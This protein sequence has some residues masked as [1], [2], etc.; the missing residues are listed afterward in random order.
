MTSVTN[1]HKLGD[2]AEISSFSHL[3]ARV[4][5]QE[6][7]RAVLPPEALQNAFLVSSSCWWRPAFLVLW[8]Q[9]SNR[10][11]R[12]PT[13]SWCPHII[14]L[15]SCKD[16][17]GGIS[18]PPGEPRVGARCRPRC[19]KHFA[20]HVVTAQPRAARRLLRERAQSWSTEWFPCSVD[21]RT[22]LGRGCI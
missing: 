2:F 14:S 21:S 3:K 18:G 17:P 1:Y 12:G 13:A 19:C 9:G 10:R 8:L 7:S 6:A 16:T 22:A 20:A 11:L 5:Y 4:R 15:F